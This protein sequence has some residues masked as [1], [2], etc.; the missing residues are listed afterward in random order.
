MAKQPELRDQIDLYRFH[1]TN[2]GKLINEYLEAGLLQPTDLNN[3][4]MVELINNSE[5]WS[6]RNLDRGD[7]IFI[8]DG[9]DPKGT[10][11]RATV[12]YSGQFST[13]GYNDKTLVRV[14]GVSVNARNSYPRNRIERGIQR[15]LPMNLD[16]IDL[17]PTQKVFR[18]I[19]ELTVPTPELELVLE[20]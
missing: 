18:V 4:D 7:E 9:L 8:I 13:L 5:P 2:A 1:R 20:S 11:L 3:P 6:L 17:A 10:M 15:V 16:I 12:V 14:S 19:K